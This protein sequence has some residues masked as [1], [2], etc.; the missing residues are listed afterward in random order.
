MAD[1]VQTF[2]DRT[3]SHL[4]WIDLIASSGSFSSYSGSCFLSGIF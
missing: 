4:Y 3:G 1:V 2:Q